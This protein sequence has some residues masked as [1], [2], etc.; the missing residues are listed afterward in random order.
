M[1]KK[2]LLGSR[3]GVGAADEWAWRCA[4]VKEIKRGQQTNVFLQF[5]QASGMMKR[6]KDKE[7]KIAMRVF[8]GI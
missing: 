3:R 2:L 4:L 6:V 5:L 1:N 7:K 8:I